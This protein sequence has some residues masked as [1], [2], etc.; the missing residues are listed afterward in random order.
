MQEI[1]TDTYKGDDADYTVDLQHPYPGLFSFREKDRD[2]FFGRQREING[3]TDLIKQNVLTVVFGKSGVGKTSL[4]RAG[5]IHGFR[6][7]FYLPVYL[8]LNFGDTQKHPI[9]QAKGDIESKIKEL[10]PD[11]RPLDDLTLWEY[12]YQVKILKGFVI[13]L[14]IFDQFEEVFT[15]GKG[16]PGSVNEFIIEI[17]DLIENRVPLTVQEKFKKNDQPV[18][19]STGEPKLRV[20]FS[21]REDYLPQLE[22]LYR[23]I[24]S[25]RFSRYRVSQ[26]K[27]KDAVDA[28]LKP[29]REI[30]SDP[31][32][33]IEI[34]KKIPGAKDA[35][36]KPFEKRSDSWENK[37]IE[38]FL[39]SLLCY[40]VNQKRLDKDEE[41]ITGELVKDVYTEDIIKDYYEK[42]INRFRPDVKIAIEDRLLT[43]DG[44]RKLE[45]VDSLKTGYGVTGKDIEE[46]VDRRIIR[47]ETRID[48]DYIELIHDV[49]APILKDN[50][51]K[52]RHEE[53]RKE[54]LK[55]AEN[56]RKTELKEAEERRKRDLEERK[57]AFKRIIFTIV[58]IAAIVFV[59]LLWYADVQETKAKLESGFTRLLKIFAYSANF[60][61]NEPNLGFRL[62]EWSY[63]EYTHNPDTYSALLNAYYNPRFCK[64]LDKVWFSSPVSE[65]IEF[66]AAFCPVKENKT[67]RFVAVSSEKLILWEFSGGKTVK[68]NSVEHKLGLGTKAAC[69]PDGK[70]FVFL[71]Y[72][73][74]TMGLWKLGE[75]KIDPLILK[76]KVGINSVAFSLDRK[77]ILTGNRDGTARLWGLDGRPD[78]KVFRGHIG[79]VYSAVF[80]PDGKYVVTGGGDKTARLWNSSGSEIRKFECPGDKVFSAEFSPD[81]KS[82]VTAD[83]DGNVLLWN[84]KGEKIQ[85]FEGHAKAVNSAL[86]SPDGKYIITGSDDETA[87]LWDLKGNQVFIFTGDREDY[88]V[89]AASFSPGGKYIL[90]APAKG[91][92]QLRL[93]D[94]EEIIRIVDSKGVPTL[95]NTDKKKYNIGLD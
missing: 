32:V 31:D 10:D 15:V 41:E 82:I 14:L 62:A 73:D 44:Y 42:N 40:Q 81:G 63:K 71:T 94:P 47:K 59:I 22:T 12:F 88:M 48:I 86:F 4:L 70:Y 52:R 55:K 3:L 66:F 26:I 43:G 6:N 91:P 53:K 38:P 54:E 13:P 87:R 60:Q 2:Y 16:A 67:M 29:G 84:L 50:R 49:L 39:L 19:Y 21:L 93:V 20:V 30:I 83:N 68:I 95:T 79:E 8:R 34:I 35:D 11:A 77:K 33:G 24:P 80:S 25:V 58:S 5:L 27:G 72:D 92:A 56:R 18:P 23:Y 17:A 1:G 90:I 37:K 74:N 28:V 57:R 51:D 78:G 76:V 46:L 65:K 7:S 9:A 75:K 89:Y 64:K 45:A 36:Y 61:N 85:A 69:S